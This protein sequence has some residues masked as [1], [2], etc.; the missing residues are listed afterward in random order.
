[1]QRSEASFF[2]K[3]LLATNQTLHPQI[4]WIELWHL[5]GGVLIGTANGGLKVWNVDAKS[6]IFKC[7]L[8]FPLFSNKIHCVEP[9]LL[10]ELTQTATYKTRGNRLLVTG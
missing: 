4:R 8:W 1:M 5:L 7:P 9:L 3:I 6:C 10:L 2:R